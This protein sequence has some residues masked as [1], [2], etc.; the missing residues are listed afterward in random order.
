MQLVYQQPNI[1]PAFTRLILLTALAV[2]CLFTDAGHLLAEGVILKN[3]FYIEGRPFEVK[4]VSTSVSSNKGVDIY[5]LVLPVLI[6]S[7]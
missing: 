7:D 6:L 4:A 1:R 5:T 2:T 3:N